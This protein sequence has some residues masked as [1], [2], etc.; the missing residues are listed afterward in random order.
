[1]ELEKWLLKH[2][3]KN[4]AISCYEDY[5]SVYRLEE[6]EDYEEVFGDKE[7]SKIKIVFHSVSYVINYWYV[8]DEHKY[9]SAKLRLEYEDTSFAEYEVIYDLDG[10]IEDDYFRRI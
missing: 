7:T 10:E 8:I 5:M 3:I 1:M 2:D 4:M 6:K 9:I